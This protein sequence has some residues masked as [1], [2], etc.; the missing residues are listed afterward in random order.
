[1]RPPS[2]GRSS[3]LSL[4]CL[5]TFAGTTT[6]NSNGHVTEAR[7][8]RRVAIRQGQGVSLDSTQTLDPQTSAPQSLDIGSCKHWQPCSRVLINVVCF[9]NFYLYNLATSFFSVEKWNSLSFCG[10]KNK[11]GLKTIS[12]DCIDK[13]ISIKWGS[14]TWNCE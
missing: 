3:D 14:G 10:S 2:T 4:R 5:W 11:Y 1:M 9:S 6:G 13:T 8:K 7:S 12:G